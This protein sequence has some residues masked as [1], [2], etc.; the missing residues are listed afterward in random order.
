MRQELQLIVFLCFP[1]AHLSHIREC[2]HFDYSCH[3]IKFQLKNTSYLECFILGP[4]L[5]PHDR[6]SNFPPLFALPVM[7]RATSKSSSQAWMSH[8]FAFGS[9]TSCWY[10]LLCKPA[11]T[12]R[13]VFASSSGMSMLIPQFS[14]IFWK[15]LCFFFP[16]SFHY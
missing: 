11:H 14:V 9:H 7:C 16:F 5:P 15:I 8:L 12:P 10:L 4:A 2:R 1:L 3:I 6:I 13:C